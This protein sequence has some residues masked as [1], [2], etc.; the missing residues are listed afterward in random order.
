MTAYAEA[1]L[2]K[3]QHNSHKYQLHI[4]KHQAAFGPPGIN[5]HDSGHRV[6]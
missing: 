5:G 6:G 1:T 2:G 4:H 3:H